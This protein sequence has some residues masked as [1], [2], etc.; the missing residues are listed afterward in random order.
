MIDPTQLRKGWAHTSLYAVA[1]LHCGQSP[2][3]DLVRETKSTK[4][5]LTP[6]IS[7]ANKVRCGEKHFETLGVPFKVAVSAD[8]V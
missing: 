7:E 3:A 2:S 6:R 4:D 5:F 1:T 8:D